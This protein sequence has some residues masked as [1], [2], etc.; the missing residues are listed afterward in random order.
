M[1]RP[2]LLAALALLASCE[3]WTDRMSEADGFASLAAPAPAVAA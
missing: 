2:L 1:L 3:E